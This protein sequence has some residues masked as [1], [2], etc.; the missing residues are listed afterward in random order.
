MDFEETVLLFFTMTG[1]VLI[2]LFH[3]LNFYSKKTIKQ[4]KQ[5]CSGLVEIKADLVK[6]FF[7]KKGTKIGVLKQE[8]D[9]ILIVLKTLRFPQKNVTFFASASQDNGTC[10]LFEQ[11]T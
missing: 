10:W 7:S 4:V 9:S 6:F 8:N 3:P 2:T 11:K 5:D 1:L